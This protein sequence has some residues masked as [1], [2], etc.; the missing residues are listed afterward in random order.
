MGVRRLFGIASVA[1]ALLAGY[2]VLLWLFPTVAAA[3]SIR[4]RIV[5]SLCSSAVLL[6]IT[7]LP[8]KPQAVIYWGYAYLF[9]LCLFLGLARY[10]APWPPGELLRQVSP[11]VIPILAFAALVPAPPSTVLRVSLIAAA[12]DPIALYAMRQSVAPLPMTHALVL[13]ASPFVAALIG[14]WM[15]RVVYGLT[16]GIVKAREVGSYQLVERLGVGGM[17]EV[18]RADHRMLARP[19]AVKLIRPSVLLGHGHEAAERLLRIFAREARAT[20][21]LSSPHTIQLYDFGVT[22]EGAFYT[23]MELLDGTDLQTLIEKF[24]PQPSERVAHLLSQA[25]HS[26]AEAHAR[27]FVH[28]DVKPANMFTCRLGGEHDFVKVLDFGLV[29]DRHP[30]A[31][32]LEDEQHFVGTPS[33]MAP[34]MVRFQAPVDA[35]ADLYGLGCVG[36]WLLTGKRVFDAQTRHDMLIM[37]AHQKPQLPSKRGGMPVHPELEA[38]IMRCLEKN[39]NKRPQAAMEIRET[40]QGLRFDTPW[41]QDRA[42]AWWATHLP[43]PADET[44]LREP[45]SAADHA[46]PSRHEERPPSSTGP[47]SAGPASSTP[48]SGASQSDSANDETAKQTPDR[49]YE[50]PF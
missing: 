4:G 17:A 24:G 25:C 9:T 11:S 8:I 47:T 22:R 20:A 29:L 2:L 31:E 27:N 40:L 46:P 5:L 3:P 14:L 23:V 50:N 36:Y 44:P 18:W 48:R 28:R 42:K 21:L 37:H 19:A 34:E 49:R 38:L 12:M 45:D 33:V 15:S 10:A 16:E 39:P 30:T 41:S 1:T 7:R 43:K 26:L 13:M 32:E 6:G 35:R